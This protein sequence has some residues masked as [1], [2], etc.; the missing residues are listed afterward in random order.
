MARLPLLTCLFCS[1]LTKGQI[2]RDHHAGVLVELGQQMKQQSPAD[3]TEGQVSELIENHQIHPHQRKGQLSC[4]ARCLLLLQ[5]IHQIH[6]RVKAN[7]FAVS[8]NAGYTSAQFLPSLLT[9]AEPSCVSA[10]SFFQSPTTI[11]RRGKT[12]VELFPDLSW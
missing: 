9:N 11:V 8:G 12:Y 1:A 7:P 5:Q 10:P 6:G 4:L 2:R 3:L